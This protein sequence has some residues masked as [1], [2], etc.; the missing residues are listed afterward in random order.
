MRPYAG[1]ADHGVET[2]NQSREAA[3]AILN[4]FDSG[5][6]HIIN[7]MDID[8]PR[9]ALTLTLRFHQLFGAFDVYLTPVPDTYNTYRIESFL[10][11]PMAIGLPVT[12]ALFVTDTQTIDPPSPRL[13]A[14]HRAIAHILHLSGAGFYI[15]RVLRDMEDSVVRGDGTSDLGHMVT[16]GL[17]GW[18]DGAVSS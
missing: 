3:L 12:R 14:V 11:P 8:R 6:A 13:L 10:P 1:S 18:L 15:D 16:L 4:M 7:G 9:N 5:V 17:G 2:Q